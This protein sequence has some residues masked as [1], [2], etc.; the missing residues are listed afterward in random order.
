MHFDASVTTTF[1]HS[2]DT[3]GAVFYSLVKPFG[4]TIGSSMDAEIDL[5]DS[6]YYYN[7]QFETDSVDGTPESSN[8]GISFV[9]NGIVSFVAE[10][11]VTLIGQDNQS[12]SV[13]DF[14]IEPDESILGQAV[15]SG[16]VDV[17]YAYTPP[18]GPF[19]PNS[20]ITVSGGGGGGGGGG[21]NWGG[22]GAGGGSG[23]GP[24]SGAPP[25]GGWGTITIPTN[26]TL[27]VESEV[28]A[29]AIGIENYGTLDQTGGT[30][31]LSATLNQVASVY[32][33]GNTTYIGG[34]YNLSGGNASI[35]T[36]TGNGVVNMSGGTLTATTINHSGNIAQSGG[37]LSAT[38]FTQTGVASVDYTGNQTLGGVYTLSSGA[39]S[40][41]SI[42][43]NGL[44]TQS[45]GNLTASSYISTDNTYTQLSDGSTQHFGILTISGGNASLGNITGNGTISVA[46]GGSLTATKLSMPSGIVSSNGTISF[47]STSATRQ[48][49]AVA[50]VIGNLTVGTAGLID[51]TNHDLIIHGG[52]N[53]SQVAALIT[54]A[55]DSGSWAGTAGI[56]SLTVA[57]AS[58]KAL[59][60]ATAG[61]LSISTFDGISVSSTDI[62]VKYTWKGDANL[63]GKVNLTDENIVLNNLGSPGDWAHGDLNYDGSVG[64]SDFNFVSNTLGD[65]SS[66]PLAIVATPEPGSLI[67]LSLGTI[68]LTKRRRAR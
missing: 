9:G 31:T 38:A 41:G 25:T 20:N 8:G 62:L 46:H 1:E 52:S 22:G 67:V 5:S 60:Y 23:G 26:A 4:A 54:A 36:L 34:I 49:S 47:T 48:T 24:V 57:A 11:S 59:G 56:T 6:Q 51:L 19:D 16:F 12:D 32:S 42:T 65:G 17:V 10:A 55:Y 66:S 33:D 44:I 61:E 43:N 53:L 45:G 39:A 35:G 50:I 63:D 3:V 13:T 30:L 29:V 18:T 64:L 58:D 7:G 2:I 40:L 68:V 28:S 14:V 15:A 27:I 37:T 21:I